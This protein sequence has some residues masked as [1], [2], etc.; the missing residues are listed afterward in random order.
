[1][2]NYTPSPPP[3]HNPGGYR[4]LAGKGVAQSAGRG[5]GSRGIGVGNGLG[6]T[7]LR[8]QRKL[9]K[10][11]ILGITKSDIRR[12]ARRGGVLRISATIYEETRTVMRAHLEKILADCVA[13]CEHARRKTVTVTDVIFA[14]KRLGRPIYGFDKETNATRKR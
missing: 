5:P 12:L 6:K 10:D 13:Y 9:L 14:L 11:N 1:M 2:P 8:R 3:Q 4:A 7:R